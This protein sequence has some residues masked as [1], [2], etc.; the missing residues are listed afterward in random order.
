VGV[1]VSTRRY[2][3]SKIRV[4]KDRT[5]IS[6]Q[7]VQRPAGATGQALWQSAIEV[8]NGNWALDHTMPSHTLYPHQWSWDSAFISIG[9]ARYAPDR[10][11][12]ELRS[13]FEAQ[14]ADG[15]VPHIVFDPGVSERD[16]FPGPGFW[17][18]P[19]PPGADRSTTGV[20]QPPVHAI[21]AWEIYRQAGTG[22][23]VAHEEL[24]W[25]YPRLVA[26]QRY[27]S[28]RRDAGGLGLASIVHPW[29][30][31][32]DNSPSWDAA[33]SAVPVDRGLLRRHHRRDIDVAEA[34]HRP[35]DDDYARFIA[36]A[37][38]YR[39]GGYQDSDLID[40]QPFVVECPGFN[41]IGAAAEQALARI[42]EVVGA[43]PRPHRDRAAEITRAL[44][45]VLYDRDTGM[46]HARDVRTGKLSTAH[47][48]NGLVPLMLDGLPATAV[49]S[50]LTQARSPRFGLAETSALPLPSYDRTAP[51][52]D[53]LRYWRG[54]V[55][56]NIN[57]LL[58]RGL[59]THGHD[60]LA[61]A[62]RASMLR[63]VERAGC[64]EYF[65]PVTGAGIGSP[66]FSWTAALA[67]DLLRH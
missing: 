28:S 39:D 61:A 45:D 48:I 54:P 50:L 52:F 41:A 10:A 18:A 55:W 49:G 59:L 66:A 65:D 16:Y 32:L 37:E 31:G 21:A 29:E 36:I 64:F 7:P 34:A 44:L 40:R 47:C 22:D 57:W 4:M 3:G 30:S 35:T 1:A 38:A 20:I 56:I 63:L 62:L 6:T 26:Q 13:L 25:L 14:W 17:Q 2:L 27:L 42:A 5:A 23:P 67:L 15:R 9:L 24:C 11:W 43:D 60:A 8:L 53:R 51:D 46:F 19:T 33:L 12:Q 58:W